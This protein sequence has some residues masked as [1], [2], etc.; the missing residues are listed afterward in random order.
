M[1]CIND[2]DNTI[3]TNKIKPSMVHNNNPW[4]KVVRIFLVSFSAFASAISGVIAVEK[5]IPIDN[6]IKIK[7]LPNETAANSVEPRFPTIKLST[8]PIKVWPSIPRIT[9]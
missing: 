7:L 5:P 4:W 2:L 6:P 9:G 3:N 1:N 8:I